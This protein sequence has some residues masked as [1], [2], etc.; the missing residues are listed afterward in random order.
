MHR[1]LGVARTG[2]GLGIVIG[3]WHLCWS[4]LVALGVAQPVIDFVFWMHFIR[5]VYVVEPFEPLRAILLVA[6]TTGAGF[7]IGA[8]F[9]MVWNAI[10]RGDSVA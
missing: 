9:A 10:G 3:G 5:P 8:I 2:I 1:R 6:V 7:A 4:A